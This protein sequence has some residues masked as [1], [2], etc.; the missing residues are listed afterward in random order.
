MNWPHHG[1]Q[2]HQIKQLFQISEDLD[3]IDFSAN[4]NPLGAPE[5]LEEEWTRSFRE[6]DRYPDPHYS[7]MRQA[8]ADH[9]GVGSDQILPANGGVEAIFLTAKHFEQ[10]RALIVHPTFLEYERACRHYNLNVEHVY[11][12]DQYDF[13]LPLDE[14]IAHLKCIDVLFLCRP[15]N[16][17]GTVPEEKQ[18]IE[19]LEQSLLEN[20][21]VVVD[22]AFVD[23]LPDGFPPLT[24][25]LGLYP[26]LI[27]LRSLTKMY[28]V[29][30]LRIG[31]VMAAKETILSMQDYQIP[32]SVNAAGAYLVPKLLKDTS[33]V[34]QTKAWLKQEL[35]YLKDELTKLDFYQSPTQ[36]NFYLLRDNQRP[37]DTQELYCFLLEQGILARHTQT[38]KGL[39]EGYLRFAVRSHKENLFLMECLFQWRKGSGRS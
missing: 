9:E 29:P 8:I 27:L 15:N 14:M 39:P 33:H 31:Y 6:L 17:T 13:A 11:L 36:V 3:L 25:W 22:E 21:T 30:G 20:V 1:G 18:L 10:K 23:F 37:S 26:N 28:S 38:F 5:G 16:P 32:W 34:T 7:V 24:R 35:V 4:L 19:L 2:S 12:D